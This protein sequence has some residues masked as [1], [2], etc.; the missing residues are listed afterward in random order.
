MTD[1]DARDRL[2]RAV[3]ADRLRAYGTVEKARAVAGVSRGS[4]DAVEAGKPVREFTLAAVE[5]ALQWPAG[6]AE[7]IL[8]GEEEAGVEPS[9]LRRAILASDDLDPDIKAAMLDLLDGRRPPRPTD[10]TVESDTA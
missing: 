6:H 4:W 8:T 10:P 7:A 1:Q 5:R 3:R 2:A 9:D